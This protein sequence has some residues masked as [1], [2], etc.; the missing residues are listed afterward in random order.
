MQRARVSAKVSRSPRT[1]RDKKLG[2]VFVDLSGLKVVESLGR[3]QYTL[4]VRDEF[5]RYTWEYDMPHTSDAAKL[6]ERFLADSRAIGVPS[7]VVVVRPDGG[8]ESR[9]GKFGD[10]CRSRG[11][12]QEF[13][14]ADSSD[15][16]E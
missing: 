13:R 3:K 11:I 9:G 8:G 5:S 10:L 1:R 16:M 2:T 12:K 15:S 4:T 7:T 6:F 14:T